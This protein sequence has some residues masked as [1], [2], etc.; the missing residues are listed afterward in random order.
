MKQHQKR[1]Q[2]TRIQQWTSIRHLQCKNWRTSKKTIQHYLQ[3]KRP[4]R[5]WFKKISRKTR[6]KFDKTITFYKNEICPKTNNKIERYFKITLPKYLKKQ[7]RT[8]NGLK[9]KIRIN[10]I[11]GSWSN[12]LNMK[13]KNFTILDYNFTNP[14]T[15]SC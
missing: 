11:R 15:I 8:T 1:I 10:K 6:K 13:H 7:F 9:L 14:N 4:L 5:W 3:P 2:R 12:V